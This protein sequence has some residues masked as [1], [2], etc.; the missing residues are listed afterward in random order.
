MTPGSDDCVYVRL[1]GGMVWVTM[2]QKGEELK[3][4]NFEDG[5]LYV[6][7]RSGLPALNDLRHRRSGVS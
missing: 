4:G 7:Q 5:R 1:A 6:L 2:M 3:N